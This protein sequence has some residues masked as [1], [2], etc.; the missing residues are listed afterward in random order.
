MQLGEATALT[1]EAARCE[2][3]PEVIFLNTATLGLPPRRTL[4]AIHAALDVWASGRAN[5][6]A[7]DD[8]VAR[9]RNNYAQ[10]VGVDGPGGQVVSGG[11]QPGRAEQAANVVGAERRCTTHRG[12]RGGRRRGQSSG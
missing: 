5:A 4:N 7:Y 11:Q 1:V 12:H 6:V 9:A 3:S 10:L 2:F 8:E